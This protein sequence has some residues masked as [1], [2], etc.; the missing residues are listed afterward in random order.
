MVPGDDWQLPGDK[1]MPT[2]PGPRAVRPGWETDPVG[3]QHVGDSIADLLV[4]TRGFGDWWSKLLTA[5]RRSWRSLLSLQLVTLPLWLGTAAAARWLSDRGGTLADGRQRIPEALLAVLGVVAAWV[6]AAFV[7]RGAG[8][9]LI[10]HDAAGRPTSLGAALRFG[11]HRFWSYVGWSL[12]A[13]V[14]V[15][16][17]SLLCLVPGI[18]LGVVFGS[19]LTGVV[20]FER[21]RTWR[22]C[23]ELARG[24]WWSLAS[25]VLVV[26]LVSGLVG[27]IARVV[28]DLVL[29]TTTTSDLAWLAAVAVSRLVQI[30][31]EMLG[32]V[33][34]VVTYA[35]RRAATGRCG[36]ADLLEELG[37]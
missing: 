36:T 37:C 3:W 19:L 10:V 31:A 18:Y 1:W 17:G 13:G 2:P 7:V 34:A 29:A 4:P 11:V 20:A 14:A 23:F 21:G 32:A 30:P 6:M 12:V 35:E 15:G 27:V 5:W 16:V 24:S 8:S 28:S 22:R 33:G 25:R 26:G 9:W